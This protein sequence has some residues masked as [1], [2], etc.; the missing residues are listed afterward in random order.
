M[1]VVVLGMSRLLARTDSVD[2]I[3]K[4]IIGLLTVMST[5]GSPR[6]KECLRS[7]RQLSEVRSVLRLGRLFGLT[8][9]MKSLVELFAAQGLEWTERKKFVEFFKVIFD[10]LYAAGDHVLLVAREGYLGEGI[11]VARLQHCTVTVGL[12]CHVLG[13]LHN[14]LD[15]R[16]ASRKLTYD[17]PSAK[18]ACT[19]AAIGAT[20]EAVDTAVTLSHCSYANRAL[21][22][23]PRLGGALVCLSGGL[24]T[25]L[26]FRDNA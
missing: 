25:Y 19:N 3:I 26:N 21:P 18:R 22:L 6:Q 1:S 5:T 2:K 11:N 8:L 14:L 4:I 10:F 15:L 7:A 9:K 20:R 16:D 17:P 13:I 24:S 23:G 12:C